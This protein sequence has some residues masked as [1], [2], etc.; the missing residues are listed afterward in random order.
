MNPIF[1]GERV[2]LSKLEELREEIVALATAW[3]SG[4]LTSDGYFEVLNRMEALIRP[5]VFRPSMRE[6]VE[7]VIAADDVPDEERLNQLLSLLH[8]RLP[9]RVHTALNVDVKPRRW[10]IPGWLPEGR[11]ALFAGEGG[12]GKSTLVLMLA[13]AIA[14]G[15]KHWISGDE[16][17]MQSLALPMDEAAPV[18][19]ASWE[20]EHDEISRRL[21]NAYRGRDGRPP[22][23]WC[24]PNR[25]AERL[26]FADMAGEGPL[27]GPD[28]GRH[29]NTAA[30]L[31]RTGRRLR[32]LAEA[33]GARLLVVDPLA[34]AYGGD[35]NS[36]PLVRSF[37]ADSDAWSRKT[38][39]T[40]LFVAHSPKS[41][42]FGYSGST[43]WQ[44]AARALWILAA[45]VGQVTPVDHFVLSC[46]KTNYSQL[47]AA[48]LLS[49]SS[50]DA[51]YG[52]WGVSG[53]SQSGAN[54][55]SEA[56]VL[57]GSKYDE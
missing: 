13:A 18:I 25:L 56:Q 54:D 8:D 4:D 19:I 44:A 1:E 38:G 39:C 14:A 23:R 33:K 36:R 17:A 7:R 24:D 42:T 15:I 50:Q 22:A 52:F 2:S 28:T 11:V 12:V 41:G 32:E 21:M 27:W 9:L 16:E 34:A 3:D 51:P 48:V 6:M 49:R 10:L 43:D 53:F 47:P 55:R 26:I 30:Q 20:D 46:P 35:E 45:G 31:T 5:S 57:Q 37:M 40:S 29:V